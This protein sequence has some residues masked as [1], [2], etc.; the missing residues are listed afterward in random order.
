[1]FDLSNVAGK[2]TGNAI[3]FVSNGISSLQHS[4]STLP[5][6]QEILISIGAIIVV[7]ALFACI[8]KVLKQELIPGYI[9][10][11]LIIGPLIL[12]IVRHTSLVSALAEIGIA[13]LLFV[14]GLEISVSKMKETVSSFLAGLIQVLV[15]GAA[16][17][18]VSRALGFALMESF[19]LALIIAFSST[20][21]VVKLLA[22]SKEL[23]TLH[24]RIA[25]SILVLQD[26]AAIF[27]LAVFSSSYNTSFIITALLKLF[28]IMLIAFFLNKTV[29]GP[30]F[31][32]ASSSTELLS[33]VA[34]A[35]VFL[36]A[37]L[38]YLLNLS[39]VIGA[40]IAGITIA[41][42]PYKLEIESKV[43]PLRDFFAII[44]F[45]SL[46]TWLTTLDITKTVIPF[47]IFLAFVLL[48]KPFITAAT[49]RLFGY[50]TRTSILS[51][52]SL[53]QIS[54]FSLIL[55]FQ[56]LLFGIL[57]QGTFNMVVLIAIITMALSPYLMR[58]STLVYGKTA[59]LFNFLN[60]ISIYKEEPKHITKNKKGILLFGCH[61]MGSIFLKA[62]NN[63]KEN[64][65][66]VDY[67]PDI[68][69][70]LTKQNVSCIYGD[71]RSDEVIECL[72]VKDAKIAIS[73]IPNIADNILL[74]GKLKKLNPQI[75]MIVEADKI[76]DALKLYNL[77]ADY[78]I[79]PQVVG[80][81][82]SLDI[83]KEA[84]NISKNKERLA[85]LKKE[86]FEYLKEL[87]RTLY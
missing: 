85:K 11:G 56:G 71:S 26:I 60:G 40:F 74:I 33:L 52:I 41:N 72:P 69:K 63:A 6:N 79:L 5:A 15:I 55:A 32:F 48:V 35:F 47:F 30:L 62:L 25:V 27:A 68:I 24:G 42:L 29:L 7:A 36:F 12:G 64:I 37:G 58:I 3:L 18:F 81:E 84:E 57:A 70:A 59:S 53:A 20:I 83:V 4:L 67:N 43:R 34:V 45:V 87:H 10:A 23:D 9:L 21:I 13:F 16:T 61:R 76:H 22:D 86:H 51:G 50:K 66:V 49:I 28:L 54:E 46:G 38:A 14:A 39:I 17:F 1:M 8:L 80:G 19:Y 2:I 77:G 44:F 31:K 82:K 78:V 73:T 75:F 65:M